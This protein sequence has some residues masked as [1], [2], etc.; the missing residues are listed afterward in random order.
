M[1]IRTHAWCAVAQGF[2]ERVIERP[3][4]AARP[5][6]AIHAQIPDTEQGSCASPRTCNSCLRIERSSS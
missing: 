5:R 3:A 4:R 1:S 6:R 2:L